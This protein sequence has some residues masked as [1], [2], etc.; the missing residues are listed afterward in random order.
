MGIVKIGKDNSLEGDPEDIIKLLNATDGG[1]NAYLDTKPQATVRLWMVYA[2]Y[3]VCLA[4][5]IALHFAAD[6]LD[7]T[8][9]F[10]LNIAVIIAS[11]VAVILTHL[12]WKHKVITIGVVII[13]SLLY[14]LSLGVLT[15]TE[16][17]E[18]I[19][20]KGKEMNVN[21]IR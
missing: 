4:L 15:P 13:L 21:I 5:I 9:T 12:R 17:A 2:S 14:C 18:I 3:I 10:I 11:G 19:K 8:W 7:E 20:D 1:I 16:T 6:A